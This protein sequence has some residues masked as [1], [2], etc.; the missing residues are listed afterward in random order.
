MNY[1]RI[2]V[3]GAILALGIG[4][5]TG[6]LA[7]WPEAGAAMAPA[8]STGLEST[9]SELSLS[10]AQRT[11]VASIL[12]D[13]ADRLERLEVAMTANDQ[14]LTAAEVER[15]FDARFVN[16]L[17]ARQ[18]ELT[19]HRRGT[20]SRVV[21]E[22]AALLSPEQ[23]AHFSDIR[24]R[25]KDNHRDPLDLRKQPAERPAARSRANV[26]PDEGRSMRPNED[27]QRRGTERRVPKRPT[28]SHWSAQLA[29]AS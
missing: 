5:F 27:R 7:A 3:I 15:P 13:A 19:A 2:V 14:R 12:V 4:L 22:I 21:A 11:E 17:V 10:A 28:V 8:V 26:I 20:E 9:L 23:L 29:S 18:A 24:S 16:Q 1:R 25:S 6:G